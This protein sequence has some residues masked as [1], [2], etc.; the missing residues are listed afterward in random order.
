MR[1]LSER[2]ENES[3]AQPKTWNGE[4]RVC[5]RGLKSCWDTCLSLHHPPQVEGDAADDVDLSH[6]VGP[7]LIPVCGEAV[8]F[9]VT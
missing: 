7:V 1:I 3:R 8:L 5:G 9:G 6:G 2:V 4:D